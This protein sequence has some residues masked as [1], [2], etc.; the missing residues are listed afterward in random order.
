MPELLNKTR[1]GVNRFRLRQRP[2]LPPGVRPTGVRPARSGGLSVG[3]IT[4]LCVAFL[5]F[6]SLSTVVGCGGDGTTQPG[7]LRFGQVGE[8][9]VTVVQPLI[10]V[11]SGL[12]TNQ[13]SA[14]GELQ[15]VFTWSSSGA[16]QL[17]ESVSY[18]GV[19]GDEDLAQSPSNPAFYQ[20]A[21]AALITQL[22]D[23]AAT[24]LF[25]EGLDPNLDPDCFGDG[26]ESRSKVIVQMDDQTTGARMRW[27]RCADGTLGELSPGG[28]GPDADAS[29][30][31]QAAV[32]ARDF[33]LGDQ[34]QSKYIGTLP[35][36]TLERGED[37]KAPGLTGPLVFRQGTGPTAQTNAQQAFADFWR[38]HKGGVDALPPQ[39][40]WLNQM[41]L[42]GA[43]GPVQEA[44]DSVEV[45]RIVGDVLGTTLVEIYE[46]QPG[47][48]CSP[49]SKVQTPYHIVVAP[50]VS[51]LVRFA[52]ARVERV[53]CI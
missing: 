36:A 29:R 31:I 18:L 40:D 16:W 49:A 1:L 30:V 21:Y 9:R 26:I 32:L 41:V 39:V 25:V 13:A 14:Q 34:W 5:A 6:L 7:S 3:R 17:R 10:V 23:N 27:T 43:I 44:G 33:G 22:N 46:R 35:F 53:P 38:A 48:F 24:K 50:R 45:R 12:Q 20:G 8:I 47:D 52:S 51:T 15:Q 37:S 42:V 11:S 2:G 4:R 28:A 19:V